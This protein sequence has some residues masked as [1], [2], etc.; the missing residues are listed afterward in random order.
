MRYKI[1]YRLDHYEDFCTDDVE[2]DED[3]LSVTILDIQRTNTVLYVLNLDI[4]I[5]L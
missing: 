1:Y 3:E 4:P 2:V 5:K